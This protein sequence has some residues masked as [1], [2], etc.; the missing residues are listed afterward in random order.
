MSI[1]GEGAVARI[2]REIGSRL[3]ERAEARYPT[4]TIR[5]EGEWY[6]WA[7]RA[8]PYIHLIGVESP[9]DGPPTPPE[10]IE[11]AR[12]LLLSPLYDPPEDPDEP[13]GWD[14]QLP[15]PAYMEKLAAQ[16]AA[17]GSE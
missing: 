10:H 6:E 13:L 2:L 14:M 17:V 7:K 8:A 15:D 1:V 12:R 3:A 9:P 4:V 16:E 5:T 11:K